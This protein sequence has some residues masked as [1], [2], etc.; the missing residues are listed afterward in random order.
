MR[1]TDEV[2]GLLAYD[3]ALTCYGSTAG[4]N[5]TW[6]QTIL[7]GHAQRM[8]TKPIGAYESTVS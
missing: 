8:R 5:R 6:Q 2:Y 1:S 7:G 3:G 4:R